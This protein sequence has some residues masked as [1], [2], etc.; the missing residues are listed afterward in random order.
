[1]QKCASPFKSLLTLS[2]S[3]RHSFGATARESSDGG[4]NF[5]RL[6]RL[7]GEG[8]SGHRYGSGC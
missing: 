5:V 1:M 3:D 4:R 8:K 2:K 7:S 6:S